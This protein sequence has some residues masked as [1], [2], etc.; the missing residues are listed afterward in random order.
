MHKHSDVIDLL[1]KDNKLILDPSLI[2]K[3]KAKPGDRIEIGYRERDGLL[4]PIILIGENGNKLTKS[5][6]VS[7][8]GVQHNT[9]TQFGSNF[10]V[11]EI[12]GI[13]ELEGDGIPVYT[14]VKKAAQ[15]VVTKEIILDT[16]YI[17]TKLENYEFQWK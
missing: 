16:N 9:L 15:A 12:D 13:L 17:I 5:N 10:W 4:H 2:E 6:T 1:L 3:L 8:R 7:F 14:D 11:K